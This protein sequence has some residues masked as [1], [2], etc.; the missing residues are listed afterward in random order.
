MCCHSLASWVDGRWTPSLLKTN[1]Q[2]WSFRFHDPGRLMPYV[3][4]W[5]FLA[6]HLVVIQRLH[7]WV[8]AFRAF[9]VWRAPNALLMGG[10]VD[11][12]TLYSGIFVRS[13]GMVKPAAEQAAYIALLYLLA[14]VRVIQLGHVLTPF[15]HL[16][17]T[18]QLALPFFFRLGVVST[19]VLVGVAAAQVRLSFG[20]GSESKLPASTHDSHPLLSSQATV[21]GVG[22]DFSGVS[23]AL[24]LQFDYFVRCCV[25]IPQPLGHAARTISPASPL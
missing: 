22:G 25:S 1:K 17:L 13:T 16:I 15:K 23:E 5:L 6:F 11:T 12:V 3:Q 20:V 14:T 21:F 7:A 10:L 19:V 4:S 8:L 2:Y 9:G 24:L 18:L